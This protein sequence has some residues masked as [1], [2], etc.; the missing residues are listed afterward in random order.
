M[1]RLTMPVVHFKLLTSSFRASWYG[2]KST[3]PSLGLGGL[4][5]RLADHSD[6]NYTVNTLLTHDVHAGPGFESWRFPGD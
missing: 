2:S 6:T 5:V 1:S 3:T 4:Q